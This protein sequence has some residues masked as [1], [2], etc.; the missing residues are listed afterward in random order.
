MPELCVDACHVND[1]VLS[2]LADEA[3]PVGVVGATTV[4]LSFVVTVI[5][6]L[7]SEDT[8]VVLFATTLYV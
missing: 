2:V 8:P 4:P 6:L 7:S 5:V 3:R 1:T